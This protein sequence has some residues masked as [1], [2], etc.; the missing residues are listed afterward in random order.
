MARM[1]S[2]RSKAEKAL[3]A[4][5]AADV[6]P[7]YVETAAARRRAADRAAALE[8]APKKR[9]SRLQV[10]QPRSDLHY[11]AAPECDFLPV[12]RY[13]MQGSPW[14]RPYQQRHCVEALAKDSSQSTSLFVEDAKGKRCTANQF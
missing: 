12:F 7:R 13:P 10:R 1:E 3:G 11:R 14:Y 9:S 5:L 6:L 2:S 4:A 8:A